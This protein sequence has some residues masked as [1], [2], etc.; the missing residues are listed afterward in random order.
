MADCLLDPNAV[1]DYKVD[2]SGWLQPGETVTSYTVTA[3]DGVTVVSTAEAD[4]V[5]TIWLSGGTLNATVRVTCHVVTS[6]G[7]VDD[8]SFTCL[9]V[10]R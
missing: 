9:V 3:T 4:G 2:W 8:R 5:V 1:L 6:A 10:N 7:R